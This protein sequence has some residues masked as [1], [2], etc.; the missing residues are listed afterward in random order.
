MIN[1]IVVSNPVSEPISIRDLIDHVTSY[2]ENSDIYYGHGTDK[3]FD[4]AV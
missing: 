1:H 3:A 2:F 4:E